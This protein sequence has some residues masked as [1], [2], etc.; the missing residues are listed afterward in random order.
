MKDYTNAAS[1]DTLGP[2]LRPYFRAARLAQPGDD[3]SPTSTKYESI[4]HSAM[5][6]SCVATAKSTRPP[7]HPL[8][9][10]V[11]QNGPYQPTH[12]HNASASRLRA[13]MGGFLEAS[14]Y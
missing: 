2:R 9:D 10:D 4:W 7:P 14:M 11:Q 1:Q 3:K 5:V 13:V 6:S 8:L 12:A